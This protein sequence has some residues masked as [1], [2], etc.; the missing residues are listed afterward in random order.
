MIKVIEAIYTQLANSSLNGTTYANGRIYYG[1][2]PQNTTAN[3]TSKSIAHFPYIVYNKTSEEKEFT[4]KVTANYATSTMEKFLI[5][6][7]IYDN[8]T[9]AITL[10]TMADLLDDLFNLM[11]D[12]F[13]ISGYSLMYIKKQYGN[14]IKTQDDNWRHISRYELKAQR[15]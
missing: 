6:I 14:T 10:E 9:S 7:D 12:D 1:V 8:D 3:S 15:S 4:Q 5:Q 2:A 11:K 13:V